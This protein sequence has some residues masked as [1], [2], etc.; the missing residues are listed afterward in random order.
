MY[1][2]NQ[3]HDKPTK[4]R[5]KKLLADPDVK[6]WY[7]NIA[8]GSTMT[9]DVRLRRLGV[10]C[11]RTKTT[12]KE[13]AQ[14]GISNVKDVEDALLDY[15]YYLEKS[16]YAPSYIEDILKALR[17]W[18]S[19]NY[20][21]LMRKIKIKDADIPTTLE[22]E[23]IP[24]KAKLR[25]VLDSAS[26]RE[27]VI[28]SFVAFAG[29]RPQVLGKYDSSDGLKLSDIKDLE[30]KA[31]GADIAFTSIPARIMVRPNLSKTGNQY[32]TYLPDVGCRFLQGYVRERIAN[33][34]R[35]DKDSPVITILKG[36]QID[37]TKKGTRQQQ[38][39]ETFFLATNTISNN[40][41]A[42]F[43]IIIKERPY[44][45]RAYFDT[46]LLL[47][48]SKGNITHAYRQF[49]MGHK[50]DIEA[51]Y[52]TNKHKLP[53]HLITDMKEAYERSQSFIV[54]FERNGETADE[55]SK[56]ELFLEMWQ[57]QAKLYGID[58]MKIKIEKQRTDAPNSDDDEKNDDNE[59]ED[60]T[61]AEQKNQ[62]TTAD[63]EI[64]AIKTAI[65]NTI[66]KNKSNS[67]NSS[68]REYEGKIVSGETELLPYIEK[69]WNI[70]KELSNGKIVIRRDRVTASG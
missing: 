35:I 69:G 70:V 3:K 15:V 53:E 16:G 34:E 47:A 44:V 30:I 19:F 33:G 66:N 32:F 64:D 1:I 49:F 7:Q 50:G 59:N 20:V 42:A 37:R 14:I 10:Y 18:L 4:S 11:E 61:T 58:P 67:E 29:L 27:R 54:P 6:R 41:R 21:K 31:N 48:E 65:Q 56:K 25:E 39:R 13:F 28:I 52:T 51:K 2:V 9:A 43:G 45:L 38:Q 5:H 12:P 57:E 36:Y 55:K 46:Q 24:T 60:D 68:D 63:I 26:A 23:E 62:K 40:I 17:S 8:R 22:N